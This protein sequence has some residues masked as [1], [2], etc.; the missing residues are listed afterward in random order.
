MWLSGL[1]TRYSLCEA[2]GLIPG[3]IQWIKDPA[4]LQRRSQKHLQPGVMV[5]LPGSQLQ[6]QFNLAWE[7]LYAVAATIK[8][9][10]TKMGH[11]FPPLLHEDATLYSLREKHERKSLTMADSQGC[12]VNPGKHP[13][14]RSALG[15]IMAF[16]FLYSILGWFFGYLC[17]IGPNQYFG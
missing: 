11:F 8:L 2:V 17:Q 12:G 5:A 14:A 10:T 3:L 7:L 4:W 6:L 16:S 1:R 9:Q 13:T 15:E